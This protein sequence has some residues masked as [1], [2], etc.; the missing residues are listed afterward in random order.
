MRIATNPHIF[1]AYCHE[2]ELASRAGRE[3]A[4]SPE[5]CVPQDTASISSDK[6][7][8]PS[9][10]FGKAIAIM[11]GGTVAGAAGV[12]YLGASLTGHPW[13]GGILGTL[14]GGAAG[15]GV[16]GQAANHFCA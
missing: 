13:V 7:M 6:S 14:V 11:A 16:G 15:L 8:G 2:S 3:L 10:D 1:G 5:T 4:V 12:G 9:P